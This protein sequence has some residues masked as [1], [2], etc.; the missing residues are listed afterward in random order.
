MKHAWEKRE[1]MSVGKH[2]GKRVLRRSRLRWESTIEIILKNRMKDCG[3]HSFGPKVGPVR[4]VVN[5]AENLRVI[6]FGLWTLINGVS[7]FL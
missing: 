1:E 4:A 5:T 3:F 7:K 2:R 6:C